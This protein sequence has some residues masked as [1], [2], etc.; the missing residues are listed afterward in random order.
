MFNMA[1]PTIG[2]KIIASERE[3]QRKIRVH[4]RKKKILAKLKRLGSFRRR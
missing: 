2:Q 4:K 3:A 1:S